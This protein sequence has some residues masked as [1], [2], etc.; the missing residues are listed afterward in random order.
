MGALSERARLHAF[1]IAHDADL[2]VLP[3]R[4]WVS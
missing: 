1:E 2:R 3:P 4:L